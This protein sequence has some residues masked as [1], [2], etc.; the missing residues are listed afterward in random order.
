MSAVDWFDH[1]TGPFLQQTDFGLQN[2]C[3]AIAATLDDEGVR[4]YGC[5]LSGAVLAPYRP[6][7]S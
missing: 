4:V 7:Q 5:S 2:K 3:S 6:L 1:A